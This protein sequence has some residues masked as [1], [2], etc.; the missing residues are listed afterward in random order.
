MIVF[1]ELVNATKIKGQTKL[2]LN[3]VFSVGQWRVLERAVPT[4]P[5]NAY[6]L[7]LLQVLMESSETLSIPGLC[8][9]NVY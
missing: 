7:R 5:Y 1:I 2:T 8:T 9:C 6:S 4:S 3:I